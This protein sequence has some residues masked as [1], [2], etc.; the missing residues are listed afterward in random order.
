MTNLENNINNNIFEIDQLKMYFQEPCYIDTPGNGRKIIINQPTIGDIIKHGEKKIYRAV[1]VFT[2]N[3]TTYR[4]F[5]WDNKIDWNK[6]TDY[7]LFIMLVGSLDIED[8]RLL[9]GDI[10]FK[11]FKQTGKI[12]DGVKTI[13]LFNKEQNIEIDEIT[14]EKLRLYMRTM[15]NIFPKVE[16]ARGKSTKYSIIEEE[17]MNAKLEEGKPYQSV[18]LPMISGCLNHPGFKY[19]RTELKDIGIV[20]FM[21]SVQRLQIY[22]SSTALL[23]GIYS[24]FVD[25]SN[26]D[27]EQINFMRSNISKQK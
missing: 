6:I 3:T 8:T 24:G 22:E 21:D 4:V 16:K 23:K 12:I 18:L 15:F 7:E 13:T 14:Y 19:K 27:P 20:E 26:I 2:A 9:F 11:L 25:G 10:N 5:L 1:N 17:K